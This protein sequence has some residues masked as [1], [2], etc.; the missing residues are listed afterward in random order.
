MEGLCPSIE[1][2][3]LSVYGKF[4]DNP[5]LAELKYWYRIFLFLV[6]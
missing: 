2:F 6:L 1:A 3:F 5:F 4:W